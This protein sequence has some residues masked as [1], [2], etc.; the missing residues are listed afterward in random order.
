MQQANGALTLCVFK[1]LFYI[2]KYQIYL[3]VFRF[4]QRLHRARKNTPRGPDHSER[5][6]KHRE[7]NVRRQ[8]DQT[9]PGIQHINVMWFCNSCC[10][11]WICS[12]LIR[13]SFYFAKI[14]FQTSILMTY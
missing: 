10:R 2:Q 6:E 1:L 12:S 11:R 14:L 3:R 9:T 13:I 8:H 5:L 7:R 4:L